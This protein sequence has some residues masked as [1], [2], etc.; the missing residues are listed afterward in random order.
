MW[1]F[2]GGDSGYYFTEQLRN[3]SWLPQI[4]HPEDSFGVSTLVRLWFDYPYLLFVKLLS[5]VGMEWWMIDK[6]LW[7]IVLIVTILS[8]LRLSR[9][10]TFSKIQSIIS[11]VMYCANTY[12]L[13]LFGGGQIGVAL[14][15]GLSPL[16]LSKFIQTVDDA[17]GNSRR[18]LKKGIQN[19][20]WL[21]LLVTFDLR[22]AYLIAGAGFLYAVIYNWKKLYAEMDTLILPLIVALLVHIFWILPILITHGKE[23]GLGTPEYTNPGM[24]KFLSF[25][26][27]SHALTL[28][29]PNWP[30]NLFGKVYF[31]QPE[32]LLLPILAFGALALLRLEAVSNKRIRFFALLALF[33]A[34]LAKGVNSPVGG[35]FQWMFSYVPGFVM[36]RDPTKFY[37]FIA[38]SYSILIPYTLGKLVEWFGEQYQVFSIKYHVLK[39]RNS[40]SIQNTIYVILYT[41]FIVFWC[42]TIRQLFAGQLTGNFKPQALP[43]EYVK[44]KNMLVSDAQPSRTLWIPSMEKFA[45]TSV[46]HPSIASTMLFDN[47][48]VS[49]MMT[50]ATSSSFLSAINDAGVRYVIVPKDIEGKFFMQDYKYDKTLRQQM[51]RV[52]QDTALTLNSEYSEIA[53]FENPTFISMKSSVPEIIPKQQK[54]ADIGVA[55]SAV[56][57][58]IFSILSL[59]L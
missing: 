32:F 21:G 48:S 20:L 14:A 9:V 27:F 18:R 10:L 50:I 56:F 33:G 57:L 31:L 59:C 8:V 35:V 52:L 49:G 12:S 22:I 43:Q 4:W 13:L 55:A 30:E 40:R 44:L 58:V 26:D 3:I 53:V 28:L 51:I 5:V 15:Y 37:L 23:A 54:L 46:V 42:F 45:Y 36:F 41:L 29:H 39:T 11:C 1:Y 24:L 47:A 25:A 17:G 19:G 34:F 6:L 38:I 2:A 16:V 7:L